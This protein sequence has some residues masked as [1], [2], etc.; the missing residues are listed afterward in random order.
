MVVLLSQKVMILKLQEQGKL[1]LDDQAY[2]H[3]NAFFKHISG[4]KLDLLSL[5]VRHTRTWGLHDHAHAA[6]TA[7]QLSW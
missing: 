5:Y 7:P 2:V 3:A 4:N 1:K 6:H